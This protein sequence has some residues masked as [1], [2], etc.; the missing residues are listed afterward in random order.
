MTR[1]TSAPLPSKS[2]S[3]STKP[4]IGRRDFLSLTASLA[5][6]L[7]AVP[8]LIADEK[9]AR[10]AQIAITLDLE[11]S[12]QY[13]TKD[14]THWDYE[15]GNLNAETKAYAVEAAQRAKSHRGVLHFFA[16]GRVFEQENLDWMKEIAAAGHP[17]GNHTYDHVN[18]LATR[19]EDI[20]FRFQ[21]A[22]W[23]IAGKSPADVIEENI[24]LC[25]A[26]MKIRTGKTPDGFRTPGG[27][28]TGLKGRE[29]LQQ[30][31]L[32]QGFS[33]ISSLYPAHKNELTGGK[34]SEDVFASI[35]EGVKASQPFVYPTG[36]IEVPMSPISDVG[37]FRSAGWDLPSFLEAIRR[38]VTW[39]IDHG[40]V[41]DFLA[42]PSCLYVTDPEFKTIELICDLVKQAGDRAKIV[43]LGT[44]AQRVNNLP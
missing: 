1:P 3:E 30:M 4:V 22:P 11:M 33:W 28:S 23:L 18:V 14:Q 10:P 36:L 13:P 6:G 9:P 2:Q 7:W 41:F 37:A 31:L 32:G 43:D 8:R 25:T 21:R 16:V 38:G 12:R 26:G 34:V 39:A 40:A 20:Q 15:K 35:V 27:F 19:P 42:H 5:A 29:D 17:I 24:R 44:I